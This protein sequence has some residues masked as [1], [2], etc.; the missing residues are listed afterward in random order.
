MPE[1]STVR[2]L[3][4]RGGNHSTRLFAFS[5]SISVPHTFYQTF[6]K[7]VPF[8]DWQGVQLRDGGGDWCAQ[9]L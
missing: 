3:I 4:R 6:G 7:V 2:G 1:F 9:G 8:V 5:S